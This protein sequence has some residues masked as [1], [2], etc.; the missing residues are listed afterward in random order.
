M[1]RMETIREFVNIYIENP[2]R[3]DLQLKIR[4]ILECYLPLLENM[5][6]DE[7]FRMYLM[8]IFNRAFF[9]DSRYSKNTQGSSFL[10]TLN[11]NLMSCL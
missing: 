1:D 4:K 10:Q 3:C 7:N 6:F 2:Y 5:T 9:I 8:Q 11:H